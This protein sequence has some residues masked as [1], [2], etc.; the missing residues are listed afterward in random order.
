[1]SLKAKRER[2]PPAGL[3]PGQL[4]MDGVPHL[5]GETWLANRLHEWHGVPDAFDGDTTTASRK[6]HIREAIVRHGLE[7]VICGRDSAT[8]KCLTWSDAFQRLYGEKL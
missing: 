7:H 8:R 6:Q 1:M 5:D 3:P 2:Q 4:R